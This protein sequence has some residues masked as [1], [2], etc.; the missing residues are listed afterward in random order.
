MAGKAHPTP[1]DPTSRLGTLYQEAG[2]AAGVFIEWRHKIMLLS[3]ATLAIAFAATS[4]AFKEDL[5]ELVMAIPLSLGALVSVQCVRFDRRIEELLG[6][7]YQTA[8]DY[9]GL[10]IVPGSVTAPADAAITLPE[11]V[12]TRIKRDREAKQVSTD[13]TSRTFGSMTPLFYMLLGVLYGSG[14]AACVV[15]AISDAIA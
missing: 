8:R 9:E 11:G 6:L 2:R 15:I 7:C 3:T 12:W 10:L 1:A 4:W 5:G 13:L 14:A